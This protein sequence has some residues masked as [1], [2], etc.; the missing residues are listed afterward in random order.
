[1]NTVG[2]LLLSIALTSGYFM[3]G[4]LWNYAIGAPYGKR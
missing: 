4:S 3:L 2:C 1:V